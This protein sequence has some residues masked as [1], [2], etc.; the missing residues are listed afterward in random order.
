MLE[1]TDVEWHWIATVEMMEVLA[2]D[3]VKIHKLLLDLKVPG[4]LGQLVLFLEQVQI[5][6]IL[7]RT[8]SKIQC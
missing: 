4:K 1:Q 5:L 7:L 2:T 6:V 3:V 8:G